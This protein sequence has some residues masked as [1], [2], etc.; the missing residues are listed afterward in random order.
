MAYMLSE[1][2]EKALALIL[3]EC[4]TK[5][6]VMTDD[7]FDG[8]TDL[9]G[10]IS[11]LSEGGYVCLRYSAH[12]EYLLLPAY[13]ARKYFDEKEK[14]YFLR[15]VLCRRVGLLAFCGAIVG[16]FATFFF[17]WLAGVLHVG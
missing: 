8:V 10:T 1:N 4:G 3:R 5:Y 6:K 2:A 12:G 7:D 15:A 17:A 16:A 13:K 14:F 9:D 11:E